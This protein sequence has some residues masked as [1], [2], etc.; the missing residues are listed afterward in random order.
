M[1]GGVVGQT[2]RALDQSR[3]C[4]RP[5]T[6]DTSRP[7]SSASTE[8][9]HVLALVAEVGGDCRPAGGQPADPPHRGPSP[10]ALE[11]GDVLVP[12]WTHPS[13]ERGGPG[14][15]P[16]PLWKPVCSGWAARFGPSVCCCVLGQTAGEGGEDA[17]LPAMDGL[18]GR[19][20]CTPQEARPA[21]RSSRSSRGKSLHPLSAQCLG[22]E[23]GNVQELGWGAV[24]GGREWGGAVQ[25][26]G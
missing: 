26:L 5:W 7:S 11:L 13:E 4:A 10:A 16:A 18:S 25:E 21:E 3:L 12:H 20:S 2:C 19:W 9:G 17:Q 1:T 23:W 24:S 15:L 14:L 22:A 8:S 6:S